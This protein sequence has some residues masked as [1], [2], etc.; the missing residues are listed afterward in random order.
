MSRFSKRIQSQPRALQFQPIEFAFISLQRTQ[1]TLMGMLVVCAVLGITVFRGPS[2]MPGKRVFLPV[3]L[4]T[5]LLTFA[6]MMRNAMV[7][8][9]MAELRR[10]PR[11]PKALKRWSRNNII[12]QS[13]CAAVGLM[14]FAMQLMG[15]DVYLSFTLYAIGVSYL[16]LLRPIRP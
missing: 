14:G 2:G 16:V 8:P 6:Y 7:L 9:S 15:A 12:M 3:I 5:S 11:D 1:R 10:N 13:L 4:S